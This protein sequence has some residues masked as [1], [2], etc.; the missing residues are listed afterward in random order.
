[1]IKVGLTG[2]Y[3]SGYQQVAEIFEEMGVPVFDADVVL[4]FM[5]NYSE[6][7]VDK[8]KKSFG[9]DIYNYG[10]INTKMLENKK[11]FDKLL[12]VVQIDMIKSYE[13]WRIK[14]WNKCYTIFK[15]SILY[16]RDLDNSMN[17]NITTYRPKNT[18]RNDLITHSSMP[19]TKI[20][21]ILNG[22][23]DELIKNR[24]ADYIIHNYN[25]EEYNINTQYVKEQIQHINKSLLK[26]ESRI[27]STI[28]NGSISNILSY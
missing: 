9:E 25:R 8:I 7:H 21:S 18:R 6:K 27:S 17:F 13:K 24:K 16:E 22:E 1:M 26:K 2:N 10:L 19:T 28:N 23:M 5:I 11:S 3:Y 12:D 20:D 15:S 14:N 4:K